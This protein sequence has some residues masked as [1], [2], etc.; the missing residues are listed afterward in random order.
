MQVNE[1]PQSGQRKQK[2]ALL[3]LISTKSLVQGCN[4]TCPDNLVL[5]H[6]KCEC[7]PIPWRECH[8]LYGKD[9]NQFD[10]DEEIGR[11]PFNNPYMSETWYEES[12][13][14]PI[15]TNNCGDLTCDKNYTQNKSTCKCIPFE[16]MECHQEMYSAGCNQAIFDKKNARDPKMN[17]YQKEW[18]YRTS[19][20]WR[21]SED[22]YKYG[23][24]KYID[25]FASFAT[26]TQCSL[27]SLAIAT[28]ALAAVLI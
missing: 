1:Y 24:I 17:P 16:W 7:T 28:C 4:L 25:A 21:I 13:D 27:A 22:K 23:E 2:L 6:E 15:I 14:L 26:T 11:E 9:C 18:W 8:P 10:Y 5:D 12:S 19:I 3:L 20:G